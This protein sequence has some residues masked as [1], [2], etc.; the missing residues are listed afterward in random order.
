MEK[1]FKFDFEN[2]IVYQKSLEL[3]DKIFA[4]YKKLPRIISIL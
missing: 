2:L 1:E 3:I 4:I